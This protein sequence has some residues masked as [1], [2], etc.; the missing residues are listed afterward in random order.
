MGAK[1]I[2][3]QLLL[4]FTSLWLLG[5]GALALTAANRSHV[6]GSKDS[7]SPCD[8]ESLQRLE[9]NFQRLT[10]LQARQPAAVRLGQ[11]RERVGHRGVQ[12]ACPIS[13]VTF[14]GQGPL[15]AQG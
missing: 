12:R 10:Q 1:R 6:A 15:A 4:L 11:V 8:M 9:I 2:V 14:V 5:I 13:R 7:S 3:V